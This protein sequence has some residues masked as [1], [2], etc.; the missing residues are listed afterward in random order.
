MDFTEIKNRLMKLDTACVM[1]A[2]KGLR[3]LDAEIR[4]VR[5]GLKMVGRAHTVHIAAG[6]D[7]KLQFRV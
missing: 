5:T 2:D 1:D 6:K 3:V 7:S 4:P